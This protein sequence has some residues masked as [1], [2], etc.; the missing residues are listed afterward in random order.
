MIVSRKHILVLSF[1]KP[2][3]T[4]Y[5]KYFFAEKIS[6]DQFIEQC[7]AYNYNERIASE[8]QHKVFTSQGA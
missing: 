2:A 1:G 4:S 8:P 6:C 7:V 3:H 5:K